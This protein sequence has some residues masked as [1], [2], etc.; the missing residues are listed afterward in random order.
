M[1]IKRAPPARRGVRGAART[2][3]TQSPLRP[4]LPSQRAAEVDLLRGCKITSVSFTHALPHCM[5]I[6][7]A[8]SM[9]SSRDSLPGTAH[10]DSLGSFHTLVD[11]AVR[12]AGNLEEA[13]LEVLLRV[14]ADHPFWSGRVDDAVERLRGAA[15]PEVEELL[16]VVGSLEDFDVGLEGLFA[17]V[18]RPDHELSLVPRRIDVERADSA[19][20]VVKGGAALHL[21]LQ[22]CV[23]EHGLGRLA[24]VSRLVGVR[25]KDT[26]LKRELIRR[27][28]RD[29]QHRLQFLELESDAER[30]GGAVHAVVDKLVH[31]T[32]RTDPQLDLCLD[33]PVVGRTQ[34]VLDPL[35][36]RRHLEGLERLATLNARICLL[37][38]APHRLLDLHPALG[39][40]WQHN[41]GRGANR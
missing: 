41:R 11:L 20:L 8:P 12:R 27:V 40:R 15:A 2:C 18:P 16:G 32:N 7:T 23:V 39:R 6:Q 35:S 33:W 28:S 38:R 30:E 1:A 29:L 24:N 26:E 22:R 3:P 13:V 17:D 19:A 25:N 36:V 10:D 34:N 14:A 5:A 21:L 31:A 37:L 4:P 9:T